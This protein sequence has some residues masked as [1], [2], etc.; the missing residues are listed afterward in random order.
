MKTLPESPSLD[1]LRQQAKD[2]LPQL[3]VVRPGA[4]LADAQ[5]LVAEQY[6]FRTWP[7]LKAEVDRRRKASVHADESVASSV[8]AAFDLGVPTGAMTGLGRQWAGYAWALTTDRGRW[9]ARELFE[10]FE[11]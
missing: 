9:L 4:T 6:G 11:G 2:V 7:D 5:A 8:A 10:W 3:R 1:H